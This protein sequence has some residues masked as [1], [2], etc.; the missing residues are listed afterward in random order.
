V[1]PAASPHLSLVAPDGALYAFP[2]VVG[3]AAR[4]FDDHAFALRLLEEEGVLVVPGSSFNVPWRDHFRVTLLPEPPVLR[5]VFARIGRLL[6]RQ[7]ASAAADAALDE[8]PR[9]AAVA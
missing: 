1:Q 8:V 2:R 3:A 4:G 5:E 6:D 7:V 9:H